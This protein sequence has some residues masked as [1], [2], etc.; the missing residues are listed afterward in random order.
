MPHNSAEEESVRSQE[1][2]FSSCI[3]S[4]FKQQQQKKL[5]GSVYLEILQRERE[6]ELR[7]LSFCDP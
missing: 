4:K 1:R 7:L 6:K 5:L 3:L 2:S